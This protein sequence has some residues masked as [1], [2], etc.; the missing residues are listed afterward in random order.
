ML[1]V[2]R[3][4]KTRRILSFG[5]AGIVALV[6]LVLIASAYWERRQTPFRNL[7]GLITALQAYVRDQTTSG[8]RL[9]AE[10]P[11]SELVRGGYL[12][13]NDM[14]A[15]EGMDVAFSTRVD[16]SQ[17][18][19]ILARARMPDGQFLCVLADGSVQ[20]LSRSRYE[21]ALRGGQPDSAAKRSQPVQPDTNR[22]SA[23]AGPDR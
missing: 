9:P 6:A 17:P 16:D 3:K 11:L 10:I 18:Q 2:G 23:A 5:A 21:E 8:R 15:F 4:M 22:T 7:P 12:T 14:R 13:T 1:G 19:G 20:Q